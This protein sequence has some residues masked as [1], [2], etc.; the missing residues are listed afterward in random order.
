MF[1]KVD[2]W[3]FSWD[4]CFPKQRNTY[5]LRSERLRPHD[6]VFIHFADSGKDSLAQKP[7]KP[8][9]QQR[10]R[11]STLIRARRCPLGT[12][13]LSDASLKRNNVFYHSGFVGTHWNPFGTCLVLGASLRR[14]NDFDD[15]GFVGTRWN[16]RRNPLGF[17]RLAETK[18]RLVKFWLRRN[19]LEPASEPATF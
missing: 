2:K 9:D 19:P 12:R 16:P 6:T 14:N 15:S 1:A 8:K 7:S 10:F 18:Q 5:G 13:L 3:C 11:W 4:A 17:G